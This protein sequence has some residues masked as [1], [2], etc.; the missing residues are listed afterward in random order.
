MNSKRRAR[1]A[2]ERLEAVDRD[3]GLINVVIDE[4]EHFFSSY[5]QMEGRRVRWLGRKD[6]AQAKKLI[7]RS[8]CARGG[9]RR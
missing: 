2:L 6:A 7:Q 8:M 5:N 3:S 9:T 4:I 1:T